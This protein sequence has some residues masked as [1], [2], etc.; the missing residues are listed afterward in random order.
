MQKILMILG[1]MLFM[2]LTFLG[3][4]VSAGSLDVELPYGAHVLIPDDW[5]NLGSALDFKETA[6]IGKQMKAIGTA[7]SP[8]KLPLISVASKT[9]SP[10]TM[11]TVLYKDCPAGECPHSDYFE[12]L[13][14]NRDEVMAREKTEQERADKLNAE[15]GHKTLQHF[16]MEVQKECT[17]YSMAGGQ[18]VAMYG[19]IRYVSKIK[20]IYAG[21][22][23]LGMTIGYPSADRQHGE[24][25]E[26]AYASFGCQA[27]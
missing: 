6:S 21:A 5:N 20:V 15:S 10:P 9:G 18:E 19:Q 3:A 12:H 23:L 13:I 26:K 11:I 1:I 22:K 17:G 25:A 4:E 16:P 14:N 2:A 8:P 7:D 27:Q 24:A